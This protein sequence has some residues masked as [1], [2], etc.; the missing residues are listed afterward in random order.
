MKLR[1]YN[2]F[3]NQDIVS[4]NID[5]E[6]LIENIEHDCKYLSDLDAISN[7]PSY[8]NLIKKGELSIPFLLEK[9]EDKTGMFWVKALNE[10]TG[11]GLKSFK[12]DDIRNFWKNWS[13]ENGF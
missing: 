4:T 2:E 6:K 11:T 12:L 1:K 8:K 9:L 7:H 13:I 10:I 3:V 5:I